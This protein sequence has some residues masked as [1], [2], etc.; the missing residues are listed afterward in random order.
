[1]DRLDELEILVAVVETG[2][3]VGAARRLRRSPPAV[4]RGLSALEARV[5]FRL[6]ER[7][8]RRLA[9]TDAALD[10]AEG[11]RRLLADYGTAV[12]AASDAPLRGLLRITAP[13]V[14][15]GR[16]VTS[17]AL[18]FLDLHPEIDIELQLADRN[19][20]LIEERLHLGIRIGALKDSGLLVRRVGFV[21]RL[22]VA[23]P[24]YLA[25]KG[26]PSRPD[27][28]TGHDTILTTGAPGAQEWRFGSG[29]KA[30][31]VRLAPRLRVSEIEAT[32]QAVRAGHGIGRVLSYQVHDELA[33]G[34][35]VRLLAEFEPE[36]LPVQI[37]VPSGPA[38]PPKVRAFL[39]HAAHELSRLPQLR[40]EA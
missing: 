4:T 15:G 10:L 20:D 22:L 7:T 30:A 8:T 19:L 24:A 40:Q 12:T 29:A 6:I 39:D 25:R 37:V 38:M 3:L 21:R 36:P 5:G 11:A 31:S 17:V 9:P 1:M 14:F 2:S 23:T 34:H 16:H 13:L 32:L 33:A 35:L 26:T 18:S 27:D 28:L